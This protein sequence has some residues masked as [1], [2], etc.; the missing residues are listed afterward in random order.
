MS[1]IS[2]AYGKVRIESS[3]IESLATLLTLQA[4]NNSKEFDYQ[5]C[6]FIGNEPIDIYKTKVT[7]ENDKAFYLYQYLLKKLKGNKLTFDFS[8]NGR[9]NF[10]WNIQQFFSCITLDNFSIKPSFLKYLEDIA[11]EETY[12]AVF[13]GL[14]TEE[15]V[16]FLSKFKTEVSYCHNNIKIKDFYYK[17]I[18]YNYDNLKKYGFV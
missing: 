5:T 8:G 16:Q 6:L 13:E 10:C 14:D 11:K 18:D 9:W 2:S 17:D 1:N 3:S 4:F 15:G 7:D 12:K